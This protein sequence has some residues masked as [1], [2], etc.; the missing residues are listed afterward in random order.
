MPEIDQP[1]DIYMAS[2]CEDYPRLQSVHSDAVI[3]HCG[4]CDCQVWIDPVTLRE[5]AIFSRENIEVLCTTCALA[6]VKARKQ[7]SEFRPK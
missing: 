5:A 6:V 7:I 4:E 1:P 3:G 2:K